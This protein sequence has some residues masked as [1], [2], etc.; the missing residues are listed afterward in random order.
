MTIRRLAAVALL[1]A[2]APSCSVEHGV[3]AVGDGEEPA[4]SRFPLVDGATSK[5]DVLLYYGLPT[6]EY[7]GDRILVYRLARAG[8][9]VVLLSRTAR[10]SKVEFNLVLVFDEHQVLLRHS[11]L[12]TRA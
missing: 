11:L 1:L 9:Q 6:S 7:E 12:R 2:L 8:D 4:F 5:T 10:W 3:G